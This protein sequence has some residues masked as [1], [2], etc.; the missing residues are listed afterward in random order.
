MVGARD[1]AFPDTGRAARIEA[2]CLRIPFVEA[3]DHRDRASIGSPYAEDGS[4]LTFVSDKVGAHLVVNAV[5]TALIEEVEVVLGKK[6]GRG[7]RKR[8]VRAHHSL[9]VYST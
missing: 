5:M 4:G 7:S 1:E 2:V 6:Q 9:I 8:G 3:A